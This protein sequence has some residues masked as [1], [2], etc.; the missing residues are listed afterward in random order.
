MKEVQVLIFTTFQ[1][2]VDALVILQVKCWKINSYC[3]QVAPKRASL[4]SSTDPAEKSLYYIHL[5]MYMYLVQGQQRLVGEGEV[6]AERKVPEQ[7]L[8]EMA[9]FVPLLLW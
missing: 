9:E 1:L 5:Q 7:M 4:I 2:H 8:V 6:D 3:L